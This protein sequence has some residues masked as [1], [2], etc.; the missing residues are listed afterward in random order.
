MKVPVG[1][2]NRHIHLSQE[3]LEQLFGPHYQLTKLKD[4]K[5][6][7][8]YAA[9]ETV[10]LVGP[11]GKIGHVRVLG[12]VRKQTQV[13][14]SRT[15]S[16]L[17]G[18]D[19]PIRDSGDL[20]GSEALTIVGP[21][22]EVKLEEGVILAFRHIHFSEEDAERFGI[23]DKQF[24]AVEVEG[25][26]SLV[27]E[28]V[29]C[30][31]HRDYRLEFHID[32]DEANAAGLRNGMELEVIVPNQAGPAYD[33]LR[34]Q[35]RQLVLV[36]NCGSSSVKYKLYD[37]P[38]VKLVAADILQNIKRDE[39]GAAL[40]SIFDKFA[41]QPISIVSHRVVH[42]GEAFHR[43]AV[44]NDE[45]KKQIEGYSR[46]APLHNPINLLGIELA[47]KFRPQAMHVAVFDT[48]FHQT[49]PP[50]SYLYALP[51]EYY[52]KYG[53]RKYGFHG[54]SHR[55]VMH[56]AEQMME[57]PKERLRLISCHIGSGV[58]VTA[59][60]NGMSLDTSMGMT[61][62]AGVTMGTRSGNIDPAILP[63]LE[64]I[65]Q[66]D[67]KGAVDILNY[68]SGLLGISGVSSDLRDVM[69]GAKEGNIRCELALKLFTSRLHAYIGLYLATMNGVD[70][71]IFTA[72]VGEN[73]AE[74]RQMICS[75][76]E[77]AGVILDPEANRAIKKE[78]FISNPYSPIKV[79]VIPTNEEM[80]MASDA[81]QLYAKAHIVA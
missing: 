28:N 40:Q 2:S 73:N 62:L 35:E 16:Y 57:T 60:K 51:Y 37:M 78:G 50:S 13:E 43:S 5:Q 36:L 24:V 61:P 21:Q 54:S 30:R 25:P 39:Y 58:S 80:I 26:R 10:T 31:V 1:I 18:V 17:L 44:I 8:Q 41:D 33:A 42:G 27:L 76:L 14:I 11:K 7:G 48:S 19:P 12:P 68:K 77:F 45:V 46:F 6:V 29:L 56:R 3:H 65:E 47:Q 52:E 67:S 59:I 23:V 4:L 71:I 15:D 69:A 64:E 55:Y 70:G 9:E 75:G 72:G 53:I 66:T 20:A 79:M 34:G 74:I 81:Y 49:M 32:T 22:G 38:S 63:Y